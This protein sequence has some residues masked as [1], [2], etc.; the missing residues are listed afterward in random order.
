MGRRIEYLLLGDKLFVIVR[1]RNEII[2]SYG[3]MN[4]VIFLVKSIKIIFFLSALKTKQL[5]RHIKYS[6][7]KALILS[8]VMSKSY[9]RFTINANLEVELNNLCLV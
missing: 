2:S 3:E 4:V 7:R 9:I 1:D 8:I 5:F 6:R